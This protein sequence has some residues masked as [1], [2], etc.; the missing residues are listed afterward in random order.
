MLFNSAVFILAFL[1]AS[2]IGFFAL[3]TSGHR[4]LAVV[5]LTLASLFFYGWWNRTF[6]S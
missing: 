1:P 5:W 6:S 2:L 3:G 4:R